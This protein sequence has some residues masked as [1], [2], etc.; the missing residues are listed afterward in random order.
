MIQHLAALP[1]TGLTYFNLTD[2][3]SLRWKMEIV[4]QNTFL[5]NDTVLNNL[6]YTRPDATDNQLIE[7]AK[8]AN[9]YDFTI[10]LPKALDTAISDRGVMLSGG[11]RQ[12]LAIARVLL[13]DPD[14]LILDEATSVLESI[15][16]RLVQATIEEVSRDRTTLLI[17]HRLSTVQKADQIAVLDQGR[18][19]EMGSHEEL[20]KTKGYYNQLYSIQFSTNLCLE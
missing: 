10:D 15:S 11:Q 4:S 3:K 18:V 8:R 17:A 13:K 9:A 1:S 12:R 20:L 2:Y 7:A 5:F 16:E 14:I 19:V 6:L